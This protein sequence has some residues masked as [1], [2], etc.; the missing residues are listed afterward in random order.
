MARYDNDREDSAIDID[1]DSDVESLSS[2]A[3]EET[4]LLPTD[5]PAD[6]VPS[7]SFQRR[8]VGMCLLFLLVVET[9]QFLCEPP[10]QEIM[11]DIICRGHF[12]DHQLAVLDHRCKDKEIQKTLAMV[13]SWSFT[14]ENLI[15]KS[16]PT[17][18]LE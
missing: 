4:P 9:C 18:P 7:K 5:L 15:R 2:P 13:R 8:V 12:P 17:T 14:V 6:I 1:I 3:S 16:S 11:E 10:T